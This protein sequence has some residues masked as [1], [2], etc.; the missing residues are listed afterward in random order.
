MLLLAWFARG[1]GWPM[2]NFEGLVSATERDWVASMNSSIISNTTWAAGFDVFIEPT[3]WP[4][5]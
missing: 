2:R 5:K 4:T 3:I 1:E